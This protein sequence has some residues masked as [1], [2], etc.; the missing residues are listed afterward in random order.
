MTPS[1][2]E[3]EPVE[4]TQ[5]CAFCNEEIT[6]PD[7]I[8][9]CE[10]E[11]RPLSHTPCYEQHLEQEIKGKVI[12]L[13]QEHL[14]YL[15][16]QVLNQRLPFKIE[17]EVLYPLLRSLQQTAANVSI[18]ISRQK[19]ELKIGAVKEYR[20]RQEYKKEIDKEAVRIEEERKATLAAER[21]DPVLKL[22]RKAIEGFMKIGMTRE[23]AERMVAGSEGQKPQ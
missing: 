19:D 10:R 13:T 21:A 15:N 17:L 1:V 14:D 16:S 5:T 22:K 18:A 7:L 23:A 6:N 4:K 3:S 8:A 20:E 11:K 2:P 12:P 9:N